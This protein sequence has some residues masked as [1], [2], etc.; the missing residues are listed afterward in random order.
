MMLDLRNV[1]LV[2]ASTRSNDSEDLPAPDFP[3]KARKTSPIR[4]AP[5]SSSAASW[6]TP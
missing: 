4:F 3:S 6:A 5:A 1:G 2:S